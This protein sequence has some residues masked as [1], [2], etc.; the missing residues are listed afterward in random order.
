MIDVLIVGAGISG[1]TAAVQSQAAGL[2][3]CVVEAEDV[4]GGRVR[5][6]LHNGNYVGD[7]GP[8]WVWPPWQ[9]VVARWLTDLDVETYAQYEEGAGLLDF[10]GQLSRHPLPG[11][12]GIARLAGGPQSIV[13]ALSERLTDNVIRCG[14]PVQKL[15]SQS[16]SIE[17]HLHSAGEASANAGDNTILIQAR[18]VVLAVPMRVALES[19]RFE[20]ELPQDLQRHMAD[21]PTWMAAQVKV[22]AHY[23]EAFWREQG[24]SGRVASRVGPLVEVHDH[25]GSDGSPAALFGFMGLTLEQRQQHRDALP[26]LVIEQLQRCFGEQ[27]ATPIGLW[28]EDWALVD[29]VCSASDRT[30]AAQHPDVRPDSLRQPLMN[31]RLHFAGAEVATESPGLID[32]ALQ[33][34]EVAAEAVIKNLV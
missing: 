18:Q 26:S 30:G 33:A 11:Q 29:T 34:G 5:S 25:C 2:Q 9:P 3:V 32:G 27:A 16:D 19:L 20:P 17:V 4:I 21:T 6:A 12:H 23:A 28:I 31:G 22:V 13:R 7:L 24:L 14:M 15:V 1:L 10:P 8:S